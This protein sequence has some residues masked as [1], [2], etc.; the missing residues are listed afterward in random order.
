MIQQLA[1][2]TLLLRPAFAATAQNLID[3]YT[4]AGWR[5]VITNDPL[6]LA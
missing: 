4:A 3:H 6:T 2:R 1:T 5:V